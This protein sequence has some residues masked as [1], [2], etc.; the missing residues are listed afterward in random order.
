MNVSRLFC[1]GAVVWLVGCGKS[2]HEAASPAPVVEAMPAAPAPSPAVPAAPAPAPSKPA[3][4]LTPELENAV[5]VVRVAVAGTLMREQTGVILRPEVFSPPIPLETPRRY[6]AVLLPGHEESVLRDKSCNILVLRRRLD[7]KNRPFVL[8]RPALLLHFDAASHVAVLQFTEDFPYQ[9]EE[10]PVRVSGEGAEAEAMYLLQAALNQEQQQ[11]TATLPRGPK[12]TGL[13]GAVDVS[14]LR[15]RM[16]DGG[17]KLAEGQPQAPGPVANAGSRLNVAAVL[18]GDGSLAGFAKP[19]AAPEL[20]GFEKFVVPQVAELDLRYVMTGVEI[21]SVGDH[22]KSLGYYRVRV[23]GAVSDP[24]NEYR[25]ARLAVRNLATAEDFMPVANPQA[26]QPAMEHEGEFDRCHME[27]DGS[28]S[29]NLRLPPEVQSASQVVQ[30]EM[31]RASGEVAFRTAPF[32]VVSKR[33]GAGVYQSVVGAPGAEA[34]VTAE[35]PAKPGLVE[36]T[37]ES[38]ILHGAP[39]CEGREVIFRLEGAPYWKRLSLAEGKWLPL[40]MAEEELAHCWVA[41]NKDA[42]FVLTPGAAETRRYNVATLALE[43]TAR[44]CGR[45]GRSSPG[46]KARRTGSGCPWRRGN[47]CRCRWRR[48]SWPTAGSR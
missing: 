39:L 20:Q 9:L 26:N 13:T 7:E 6:V 28:F 27:A 42:I 10:G 44:R 32:M 5:V 17:L 25:T 43:K 16:A 24:L 21:E 2:E 19:G 29:L 12:G 36:L 22:S 11:Q 4:V 34:P 47:G 31:L 48:R 3:L 15:A 37:T 33:R 23:K 18:A 30:V 45:G 35:A 41:G 46:W 40:P 38:R 14:L 8:M 1:L